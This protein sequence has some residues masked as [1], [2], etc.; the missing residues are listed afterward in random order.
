M[1]PPTCGNSASKTPPNH[2]AGSVNFLGSRA[3]PCR[4]DDGDRT[5][6]GLAGRNSQTLASV[7]SH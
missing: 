6:C 1:R 5:T 7:I 3:K 4:T 2:G